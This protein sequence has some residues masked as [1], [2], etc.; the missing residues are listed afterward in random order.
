MKSSPD[1]RRRTRNPRNS[2]NRTRNPRRDNPRQNSGSSQVAFDI[3]IENHQNRSGDLDNQDV[4]IVNYGDID[5][6][7]ENTETIINYASHDP[8][9]EPDPFGDDLY[10][11]IKC[12]YIPEKSDLKTRTA[13]RW[14]IPHKVSWFISDDQR[15]IPGQ[16]VIVDTEKGQFLGEVVV[17]SEL[18]IEAHVSTPRTILRLADESDFHQEQKH[19]ELAAKAMEFAKTRI[20]ALKMDMDLFFVHVL[21]S[22]DKILFFFTSDNRVDFRRLVRDLAARFSMRIEMRQMGV[23]DDAKVLGG[24]GPC[25]KE[26]CC[27]RHLNKFIPVSIRMAKDQNLVLNPQNV[28]GQC[29]RLKCCLAY[30]QQFYQD[31]RRD[32]PRNGKRVNTPDG[33]GRVVEVN[34][35]R[36]TIRCELENGHFETYDKNLVQ[37]ITDHREKHDEPESDNDSSD[38]LE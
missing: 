20:S 7:S 37:K 19:I 3:S 11:N 38:K 35:L 4:K 24:L 14:G 28:S 2:K 13:V 22:G 27:S 34:V 16:K 23:R 29:G 17:G 10:C 31:M 15:F 32:M 36:G 9:P 30:E 26:L 8:V 33:T 12:G 5:E 1:N 25:G 6:K 21:H 18:K